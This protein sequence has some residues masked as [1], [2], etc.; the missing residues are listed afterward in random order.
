MPTANQIKMAKVRA[1][2]G[3]GKAKPKPKAKPKAKKGGCCNGPKNRNM[4][5]VGQGPKLDAIIRKMKKD[6][7][8]S[9]RK[10]RTKQL[11]EGA[12]DFACYGIS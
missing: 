7:A 8:A 10:P 11:G 12:F 9:I 2:K 3:K 6:Q 4:N 5:M 1:A